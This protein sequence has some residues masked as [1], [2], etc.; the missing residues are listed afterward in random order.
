MIHDFSYNANPVS[1]N[2]L[3]NMIS[4]PCTLILGEMKELGQIAEKEHHKIFQKIYEH[5]YI[6]KTYFKGSYD[7]PKEFQSKI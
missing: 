7:I 5:P 3:L 2:N 1:L 6:M 4:E